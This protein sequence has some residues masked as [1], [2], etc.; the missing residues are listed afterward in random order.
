MGRMAALMTD[1]PRLGQDS[2]AAL[3]GRYR[4][5]ELTAFETLYDR[6]AP[7]LFLYAKTQVRDAA[8]AEDVVQESFIRLLSAD[9]GRLAG[10]ARPFLYTVARNL[11]ADEGRRAAVR[12]RSRTLLAR[13]ADGPPPT[14]REAEILAALD[15]LPDDQREVVL[16]KIYSGLTFDEIAGLT[17]AAPPTVMSRYRYALQ[18]LEV[19]LE[20]RHD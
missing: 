8:F 3:L 9:P 5:G 6:H 14:Q 7:A 2:D 18:K 11:I 15:R 10:S 13:Q 16:L 1:N 12:S 20:D 17:G 4:N 19:L